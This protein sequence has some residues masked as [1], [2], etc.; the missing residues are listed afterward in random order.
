MVTLCGNYVPD[1]PSI[2]HS[3][4]WLMSAILSLSLV[5][6]SSLIS[7]IAITESYIPLKT[8]TSFTRQWYLEKGFLRSDMLATSGVL[9]YLSCRGH[10]E[11]IVIT[12][13][14]SICKIFCMQLSTCIE[15]KSRSNQFQ[16]KVF[17]LFY[18][19]KLWDW[20]SNSDADNRKRNF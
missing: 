4:C 19:E 18:K 13:W 10:A 11:G 3:L 12:M 15:L 8:L 17:N 9:Q 20:K 2:L 6:W 7:L 1:L 16:I 5:R 14:S